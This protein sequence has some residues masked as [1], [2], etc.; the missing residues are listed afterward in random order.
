MNNRFIKYFF[1]FILILLS[2]NTNAQEE[3]KEFNYF[4]Y[5]QRVEP[6]SLK[7]CLSI[8][9]AKLPEDVV[10]EAS[11]WI[12][13]PVFSYGV[14]FGVSDNFALTGGIK[15]NFITQHFSL[16]T[17][18][19]HRW[20]KFAV[21][22]GYDGAFFFGYLDNFGF[23]S[24][25]NGWFTYPNITIGY[26]FKKFTLALRTELLILMALN[27]TIDDLKVIHDIGDYIGDYDGISLGLYIEQPFWKRAVVVLG[28]KFTVSRFYYPAWMAFT[29]FDRPLLIAETVLGFNL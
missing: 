13:A 25:I 6:A 1:L 19:I 12:F 17:R 9:A 28:M 8:Y 10:E 2:M 23:K 24:K 20:E 16:G 22:L 27:E 5:P 18:W 21:S 29:R 26:Q 15:S 4:I 14:K 11:N 3:T 7:H